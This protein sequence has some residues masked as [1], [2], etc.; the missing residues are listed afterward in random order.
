[1]KR[2]LAILSVA[3]SLWAGTPRTEG[4]AVRRVEYARS[5]GEALSGDL[6]LPAAHGPHPA[7]VAVHGGG[8]QYGDAGFYKHW[9]PY[10]AQRGYALFAIDYRLV[11][12][13]KHRYPAAV[14]DVSAAVRFLRRRADAFGLDP[15]RLGLLGDSAG[16]HLAALAGLNT[17]G[18]TGSRVKASVLLYGVYDLAAQW[19]LDKDEPPA[20]N[21]SETFLGATPAEAPA[22]YAEA[23]PLAQAAHADRGTA[24]FIAWGTADAQVQPSTQSEPF[25][26]A[27]AAAGCRV[28]TCPVEGAGHAWAMVPI[29][30]QGSVALLAPRLLDFLKRHL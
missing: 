20:D 25:A 10:L 5:D 3:A 11:A 4:Y 28:E 22:R 24:Y 18:A 9:G 15:E 27:L 17:G 16:A 14:V 2:L 12:G 21:I 29:E 8:W 6:Y 13:A 1:M 7:L 26:K 23:S 19:T 30:G